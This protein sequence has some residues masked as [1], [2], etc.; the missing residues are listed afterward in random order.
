MGNSRETSLDGVGG[1]CKRLPVRFWG[2][3][4]VVGADD[5]GD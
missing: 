2:G 4:G 1:D 3:K 5:W